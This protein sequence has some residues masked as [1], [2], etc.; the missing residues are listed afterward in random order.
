MSR[1]SNRREQYSLSSLVDKHPAVVVL[2]FLQVGVQYVFQVQAA[3]ATNAS[4]TNAASVAVTVLPAGLGATIA[5]GSRAIGA[6]ATWTLDDSGSVD[7]DRVADDPMRHAWSCVDANKAPCVDSDG[8]PFTP[9][10]WERRRLCC[11]SH[12]VS[13]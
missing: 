5:G 10:P 6:Q 11:S 9:Q 2:P 4:M 3:V 1:T 12:R 8:N 7:N 13:W